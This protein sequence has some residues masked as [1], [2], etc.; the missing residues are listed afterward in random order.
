MVNTVVH[1]KPRRNED[2]KKKKGNGLAR[3][4]VTG[5]GKARIKCEETKGFERILAAARQPTPS[6]RLAQFDQLFHQ[7]IALQL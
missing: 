2:T 7:H 4:K 3:V 5:R 1:T 6:S